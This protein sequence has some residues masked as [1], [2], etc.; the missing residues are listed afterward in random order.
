MA[1]SWTETCES[2]DERA[3]TH[4]VELELSVDIGVL[5]GLN[6]GSGDGVLGRVGSELLSC[7]GNSHGEVWAESGLKWLERDQGRR[8]AMNSRGWL[9]R[10]GGRSLGLQ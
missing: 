4:A 6:D 1:V 10:V 5:V 2:K 7:L 3:E 9:E 8:D